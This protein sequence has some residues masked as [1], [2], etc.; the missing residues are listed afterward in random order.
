MKTYPIAYRRYLE[1]MIK[2]DKITEI[3]GYAAWH[4][5]YI[6]YKHR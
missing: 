2:G 4:A 3:I 5:L 1:L 6:D